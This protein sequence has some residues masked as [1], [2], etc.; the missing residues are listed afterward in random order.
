[1][2]ASPSA[3]RAAPSSRS[4]HSLPERQAR[5]PIDELAQLLAEREPV[6]GHRR[7]VGC[8]SLLAGPVLV[9]QKLRR[10]GGGLV[11]VVGEATRF[12][13][14]GPDGTQQHLLGPLL[15]T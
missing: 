5:R 15:E 6:L 11:E 13:A 12:C 8:E 4:R 3:R 2:A 14:R 7:G 10:I 9:K 1:M